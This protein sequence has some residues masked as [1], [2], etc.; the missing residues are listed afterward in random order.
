MAKINFTGSMGPSQDGAAEIGASP[1]NTSMC[2]MEQLFSPVIIRA[3]AGRGNAV[4]SGF[5]NPESDLRTPEGAFGGDAES[6]G[7]TRSELDP[8]FSSIGGTG[9]IENVDY[10]MVYNNG[11]PQTGQGSDLNLNKVNRGGVSTVV[12]NQLRGPMILSGWGFDIAERPVPSVGSDPF[13]FDTNAVSDRGLWKSGPVDLRWDDQRKVWTAGHQM[14]HGIALEAITSPSDPT[15]ATSF[16]VQVFR[17]SSQ[18]SNAG[19]LDTSLGEVIIASNRDPSLDQEHVAGKVYVV[20]ARINYEWVPVWVG[21]P[22]E[23]PEEQA[24]GG[25]GGTPP[26][27]E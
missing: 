7:P 25:G 18:G 8:Y 13:T 15:S 11:Q 6:A 4:I 16:R 12:T 9:W 26:P 23:D 19:G 10:Q 5:E 3:N 14:L 17:K 21:C 2:S 27:V 22:E 24:G 1:G 20:V